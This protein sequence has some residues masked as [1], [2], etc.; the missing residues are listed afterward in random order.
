MIQLKILSGKMAGAVVAARRFPFLVGRLPGSDLQMEEPGVWDK[1]LQIDFQPGEGFVVAT[2]PDAV[3]TINGAPAQ[4]AVLRNGDLIELGSIKIR[5][6]LGEVAQRS[7]TR[8]E[9]FVWLLI[10]LVS[11]GQ[12][13]L[14]YWMSA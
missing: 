4:S 10:V 11:L 14:I 8:R 9:L 5:F 1:H 3:S 6:W 7:L 13:A 12:I 2:Q